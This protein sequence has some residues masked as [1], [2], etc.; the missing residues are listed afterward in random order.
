MG[1]RQRRVLRVLLEHD[2]IFLDAVSEVRLMKDPV[3]VAPCLVPVVADINWCGVPSGSSDSL[4]LKVAPIPS[5]F[6][7]DKDCVLKQHRSKATF[8]CS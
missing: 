4:L 1:V 5:V 6:V 2:V 3:L 8:F 7:E